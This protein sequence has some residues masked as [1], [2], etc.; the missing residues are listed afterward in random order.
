M[1]R[2]HSIVYGRDTELAAMNMVSDRLAHLQTLAYD[3]VDE[4]VGGIN[5]RT[6]PDGLTSPSA[7]GLDDD[8]REIGISA[9]SDIDDYHG[10]SA[11][12][13]YTYNRTVY[14]FKWAVDVKYVDPKDLQ[15][16]PSSTPTLAKL[17]ILKLEEDFPE[18]YTE[19]VELGRLPI[20]VE[21]KKIFSPGGMTLH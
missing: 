9:A 20:S 5:Q 3:E 21:F 4:L 2:H 18:N 14:R 17:V 19:E 15:L 16:S 1:M 8:E 6:T 11:V 13:T 7:F 10:Y 12:E